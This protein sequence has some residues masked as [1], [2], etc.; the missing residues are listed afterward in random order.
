MTTVYDVS[1]HPLLSAKAKSLAAVSVADPTNQVF[2][3][4]TALA[5][6]LL[7][8]SETTYTGDKLTKIERAL[9]LQ[10]N[11]QLLLDPEVFFKKYTTSAQSKQGVGYRDGI[12]LVFPMAAGLVEEAVGSGAWLNCT[13]VRRAVR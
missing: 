13:S 10:I 8:V 11:Y 6:E 1:E 2:V 12:S 5:A 9:A 3:E 4:Q 7:G